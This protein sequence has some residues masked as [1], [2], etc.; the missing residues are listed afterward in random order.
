MKEDVTLVPLC[1]FKASETGRDDIGDS[2]RIPV[3]CDHWM[4]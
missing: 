4:G 1:C 3:I 2:A